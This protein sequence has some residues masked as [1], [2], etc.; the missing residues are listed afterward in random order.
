MDTGAA[1]P[2]PRSSLKGSK[3]GQ[4]S[5]RAS[6]GGEI[7]RRPI[8][9]AS[10][11]AVLS[12]FAATAAAG[13]AG[14]LPRRHLDPRLFKSVSME[15]TPQNGPATAERAL[16]QRGISGAAR[17]GASVESVDRD[18]L[19]ED[20]TDGLRGNDN[21]DGGS[22]GSSDGG[23]GDSGDGSDGV[24]E[25][26]NYP[27]NAPATGLSSVRAAGSSNLAS[28][29]LASSNT[30]QRRVMGGSI[31][32]PNSSST[33]IAAIAA[34]RRVRLLRG[35]PPGTMPVPLP[36][37]LSSTGNNP[38]PARAGSLST[39]AW[40]RNRRAAAARVSRMLADAD[41]AEMAAA[42]VASQS[43]AHSRAAIAAEAAAASLRAQTV[44]DETELAA[45]SAA[46][47]AAKKQ[48]APLVPSLSRW[49]S[50]QQTSVSLGGRPAASSTLSQPLDQSQ[51][52]QRVANSSGP[53][54]GTEPRQVKRRARDGGFSGASVPQVGPPA[55]SLEPSRRAGLETGG[56]S[57][58]SV[59]RTG[60]HVP[61]SF[62]MGAP[63]SSQA[64]TFDVAAFSAG[65]AAVESRPA[66]L[67]TRS[68]GAP[69][70]SPTT[71][72][73]VALNGSTPTDGPGS[74]LWGPSSSQPSSQP[75]GASFGAPT[76]RSGAG[77]SGGGF[78][79]DS[80]F[81]PPSDKG[82]GSGPDRVT[83]NRPGGGSFGGKGLGA[84]LG[85]DTGG[86]GGTPS[87]SA[88]GAVNGG[89]A[90]A[91]A[92]ASTSGAPGGLKRSH[93][94]LALEGSGGSGGAPKA[95]ATSSGFGGGGSL[96]GGSAP[97]ASAGGQGGSGDALGAGAVP[98]FFAPPSVGTGGGL[99][100][101]RPAAPGAH[102]PA[103]PALAS[104]A[105]STGDAGRGAG[106]LGAAPAPFSFG[107]PSTR[108]L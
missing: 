107:L 35:S 85:F 54:S 67:P 9:K 103:G 16:M 99:P 38:D 76:P 62:S 14:P 47:L 93:S 36:R 25:V 24:D 58:Q 52:P 56:P 75:A 78:G 6:F 87:F 77:N 51:Q 28:N 71:T 80:S 96:F 3:S 108:L 18:V 55:G 84:S 46:S 20:S 13:G 34:A 66:P 65:G 5:R 70:V 42:A 86:L 12:S 21:G 102:P 104:F 7:T 45:Q 73:L 43:Q 101:A 106:P 94:Q 48:T 11:A 39:A 83:V 59:G 41:A 33:A 97:P 10:S 100:A 27:S 22:A 15:W 61:P 81:A 88:V 2:M 50:D 69:S 26:V 49:E 60:P 30:R 92:P 95:A 32:K 44:A 74:S 8:R 98:S 90:G 23:G 17:S 57:F 64:S 1:S 105:S 53:Q 37:S 29:R 72:L 4:S 19:F 40:E 68:S 91:S 31:Q 79:G 63:A 89:G 82:P